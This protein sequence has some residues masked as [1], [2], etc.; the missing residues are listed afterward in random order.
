MVIMALNNCLVDMVIKAMGKCLGS[1]IS[2]EQGRYLVATVTMAYGTNMVARVIVY[3]LVS[4]GDRKHSSSAKGIQYYLFDFLANEGTPVMNHIASCVDCVSSA[5][6][7][8]RRPSEKNLRMLVPISYIIHMLLFFASFNF[9]AF[10]AY[11]KHSI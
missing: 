1:V 2:M 10:L 4:C 7:I 3:A 8:M 11:K 9:V 5:A 6:T